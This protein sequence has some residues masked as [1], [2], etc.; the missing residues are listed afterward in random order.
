MPGSYR[1]PRWKPASSGFPS[2]VTG[3]RSATS[4]GVQRSRSRIQKFAER[5]KR[6]PTPAEREFTRILNTVDGGKLRDTFTCEG[7]CF[8]HCCEARVSSRP[9]KNFGAGNETRTRDLNLGK[10]ALYQLSYSRNLRAW[11]PKQTR[12]C[13]APPAGVKKHRARFGAKTL[14]RANFSHTRGPNYPAV[15]ARPRANSRSSTR[16]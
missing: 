1:K 13:R 15:R 7:A 9:A 8:E 11:C 16:A 14:N 10:V 3:D 12:N 4:V 6:N 5:L 2:A